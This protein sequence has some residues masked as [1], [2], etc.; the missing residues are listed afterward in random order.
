MPKRIDK[1]QAAIDRKQNVI[2]V[3][4][5]IDFH[6]YDLMREKM[7]MLGVKNESTIISM[8]IKNFCR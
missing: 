1:K 5:D 6:N 2:R 8:A 4:S 3:M 7:R